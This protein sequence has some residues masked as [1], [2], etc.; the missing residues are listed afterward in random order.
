MSTTE[1]RTYADIL[2]EIRDM[3]EIVLDLEYTYFEDR[4]EKTRALYQRARSELT[5]LRAELAHHPRT[6]IVMIVRRRR[7]DFSIARLASITY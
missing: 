3:E 1:A 7:A 6:Q 2:A 4:S 5:G